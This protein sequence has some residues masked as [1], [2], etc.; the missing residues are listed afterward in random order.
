MS[1]RENDYQ[2]ELIKRIRFRFSGCFVL[3]NDEQYCQGIPDL[4][5]F[6]GGRYAILEVKRNLEEIFKQSQPNQQYYINMFNEM[7]A[8][9]DFICPENEEEVLDAVQRAF[10]S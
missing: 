3:K 10:G 9:A 4:T 7:G 5:I 8:I 6:Y 1:K 2:S